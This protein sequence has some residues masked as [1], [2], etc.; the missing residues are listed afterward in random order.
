MES[1]ADQAKANQDWLIDS[2]TE[3]VKPLSRILPADSEVVLHDLR[4]LPNSIVALAGNVT[5]RRVGDP[6]T[7]VLLQQVV[8]GLVHDLIGYE[9]R[10]ADG[11]RLRSST[12]II[13]D[14]DGSPTAALC[15]NTEVTDAAD[16]EPEGLP[17]RD[18]DAAGE[19]AARPPAVR[20]DSAA[21]GPH[22]EVFVRDVEELA[23]VLLRD[24][25]AAEG[26]PVSA[27][28]KRNK[29]SVV[30][31][32]HAVGMFLLRD[33]IE[34][35]AA[36]LNVSKFTIYNYLNEIGAAPQSLRPLGTGD[37]DASE[38]PGEDVTTDPLDEEARAEV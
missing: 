10:T 18:A 14:A 7:N 35:V 12:S 33:A 23:T 38:T 24:A 8:Q 28:K 15:I 16:A 26:V 2:L 17:W 34:I 4:R 21:S 9:T 3:F 19:Q 29:V 25:I 36:A 22:N 20:L 27:M 37:A 13:R 32:L 5:G 1:T 30:T 11:R 31:R 6:A